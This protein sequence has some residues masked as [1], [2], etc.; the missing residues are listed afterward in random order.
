MIPDY[1][2]I[3]HEHHSQRKKARAAKR[4]APESGRGETGKS[5]GKGGKSKGGK[6]TSDRQEIMREVIRGPC[7]KLTLALMMELKLAF[8]SWHN[9]SYS[10]SD[11]YRALLAV[12]NRDG[13]T[14]SIEERYLRSKLSK[15]GTK[16]PSR[17][18]VPGI[19]KEARHDRMPI[20]CKHVIRRPALRVR[21][22]GMLRKPVDVSVDMHDIPF[23]GKV[24]DAFYVVRSKGKKGT[25]RFNRLATLHCVVNG[26]RL[27]LGVEVAGRGES[28]AVL[29]RL[30]ETCRRHRIAFSS[31]TRLIADSTRRA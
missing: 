23:Y 7:A 10:L 27:T 4:N 21:R 30:L 29:R 12:C 18:W 31:I 11:M 24:M 16:L 14:S 9:A 5:R 25:T 13:G 26:S 20:R 28:G 3:K 22:R 19:L 17:S 8:S 15:D 2:D 6:G 1:Y